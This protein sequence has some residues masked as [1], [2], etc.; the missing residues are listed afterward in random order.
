MF[1]ENLTTTGIDVTDARIGDRWRVGDEVVLE[2]SVP[3]IPCR[4]F[5]GWLAS[6]AG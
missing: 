3:R 2:V 4:T 1:G 5:A 6:A